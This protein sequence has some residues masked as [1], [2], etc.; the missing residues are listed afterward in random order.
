MT[1]VQRITVL[2]ADAATFHRLAGAYASFEW[3]DGEHEAYLDA[4]DD[5]IERSRSAGALVHVGRF[6][7]DGYRDFCRDSDLPADS[8]STRSAFAARAGES[9][10]AREWDGTVRDLL[11]TESLLGGAEP[12]PA[13][14]S[15]ID[16]L[17]DL[18]VTAP[19]GPGEFTVTVSAPGGEVT[20]T[21]PWERAGQDLQ[22]GRPLEVLFAA[23][24][25]GVAHSAGLIA[26]VPTGVVLPGGIVQTRVLGWRLG[27]NSVT[28][29]ATAEL[30]NAFCTDATTGDLL[31][32][33]FGTVYGRD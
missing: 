9:G 32:P 24:T 3:S 23:V 5:A 19:P 6:D 27:D 14:Q 26:R 12:D 33:E 25:A 15:L 11:L 17:T 2:V 21:F 1:A 20:V 22:V 28:E 8:A 18:M 29:I 7:H 10:S 30:F 4:H 16:E 31:A 13:A